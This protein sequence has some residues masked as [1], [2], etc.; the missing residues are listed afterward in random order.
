[1]QVYLYNIQWWCSSALR[2]SGQFMPCLFT[3]KTS[4]VTYPDYQSGRPCFNQGNDNIALKYWGQAPALR[5]LECMSLQK[6]RDTFNTHSQRAWYLTTDHGSVF[7]S[8]CNMSW[9]CGPVCRRF[10]WPCS[11]RSFYQPKSQVS[12]HA[13]A[14]CQWFDEAPLLSRPGLSGF[15]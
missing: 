13:A 8:F 5:C 10:G 7:T 9:F 15:C 4:A 2:Q 6:L 1:M 12:R 11:G 3:V 14:C